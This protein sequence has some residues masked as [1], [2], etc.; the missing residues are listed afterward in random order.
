LQEFKRVLGFRGFLRFY[1]IPAL[2][3][4][5]FKR[6]K[7]RIKE[8]RDFKLFGFFQYSLNLFK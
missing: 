8:K 6:S 1:C 5:A 3:G 2:K 7:T 4:E